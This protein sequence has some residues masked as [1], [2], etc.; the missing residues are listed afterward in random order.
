MQT[1]LSE[2]PLF[3]AHAEAGEA[4]RR[5]NSGVRQVLD[6]NPGWAQRARGYIERAFDAL[7][8]GTLFIGEDLRVVCI[9][10]GLEP[11]HHPNAWGGVIGAVLRAAVAENRAE[12]MGIAR[13]SLSQSHRRVSAQY[14]K[15]G[16]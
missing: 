5:R 7:P 8:D 15:L 10:R 13:A 16:A 4:A 2:L 3:S 9:E 12:P 11:P 14:R 1:N 6:N